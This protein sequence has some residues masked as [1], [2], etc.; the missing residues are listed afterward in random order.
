MNLPRIE[1]SLIKRPFWV[2]AFAIV[3]AWVLIYA[4]SR[5]S[6]LSEA[7]YQE[8][9]TRLDKL[10]RDHHK[11]SVDRSIYAAHIER[12]VDLRRLGIVG[13]EP[14]LSWVEALESARDSLM[15]PSLQYSIAPQLRVS[16]ESE[17]WDN[18]KLS[19]NRSTMTLDIDAV[20]EGDLLAL[21]DK[22]GQ[23][24]SGRFEV[25]GCEMERPAGGQAVAIAIGSV[26]LLAQCRLD[27]YTVE[28]LGEGV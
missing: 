6:A 15:I 9:Y 1:W 8:A 7:R 28:L 14:R 19:L 18:T 25:R 17:D 2:A 3:L 22:L 10:V 13:D 24:T 26:N 11:A 21:L 20:H 4:G 5:F 12:F 27:W 23:S 16:I